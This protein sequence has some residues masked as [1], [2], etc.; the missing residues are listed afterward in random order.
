MRPA[1]RQFWW[2]WAGGLLTLLKFWLT[3]GQPVYGLGPAIHDDRLF[4]E[5]AGH[6]IRGEWLGPYNQ[7]TLAK[8]PGFPLFL[9][10]NFWLGLPLGLTQQ[11]LYAL[12]CALLVRAL[13][14]WLRSAAVS[15]SVY[16]LLLLN[17]MSFEGP[18]LTRLI[19]QNL[20][21]PL[22]LLIVAGLIALYARRHQAF[23]RQAPWAALAGFS[24]GLFW[25]TRE[26]GVWL[27]PGLIVL[28]AGLAW[29]LRRVWRTHLPDAIG[30]AAFFAGTALAP[31]L[32]VCSLNLA[33]YGWFGTVE[34]RAPEF[35]AAY[36]ALL[37]LEQKPVLTPAV[38]VSQQMREAAYA[39][40][41]AC[42]GL[43]SALEG[44]VG[45]HW[46]D[47][48]SFG[49]GT[50]EIRGGWF[51]WALR[52]AVA[53]SGHAPNAGEA[54]RYYQR[55]ADELNAAAEAGRVRAGPARSG[56]MPAVS[57]AQWPVL[58]TE[59][60]DYFLFFTRFESFSTRSPESTG[61]YAELLPL[62][63]ISRDRLSPAPRDPAPPSP[64]QDRLDARKVAGLEAIGQGMCAL[65]R[66][67]VPAAHLLWLLRLA[68]AAVAR[69]L[70]FLQLVASA[71]WLACLAQL[72]INT[73]V[74]VTSFDYKYPAAI[75][76]SYPL[77]LLFVASVLTD[78]GG[79]W[80]FRRRTATRPVPAPPRASSRAVLWLWAAGTAL[81]ILAFRLAEIHRHTG[82]VALN[83]Q[84]KIEAAD[85][86][87]PWLDG[88][89]RPWTFFIPHFEHVPAWTRLLAWLEVA[90]TGR[91]D[92][93]LQTT[94]NSLLYAGYAALLLRWL[95]RCLRPLALGA[96]TVL[97]GALGILPH[98]W[99]N[100]TWGF[101]SQFPFALLFLLWQADGSFRYEPGRAGWWRAQA[102]GVAGLFTL[103][104]MWMAPLAVVLVSLWTQPR[105]GDRRRLWPLA[106]VAAGLGIIALVR[107]VAP[108]GGAFAQ[109]AGSPLQFLHALLD[110]LGW[111]AGRPGAFILL[112]LPLLVFAL[113]LRR[114]NDATAFDRTALTLGLWSWGQ[115]AALAFA[116]SADYSGY[117]SR[118]DDLLA[119]GLIANAVAL[120][121]LAPALR[122]WRPLP[123]GFITGWAAVACVGL[124]R[125]STGGHAAYFHENSARNN[126]IRLEAVQAYLQRHDRSLLEAPE[127]RW[128]LYQ[129]VG[130][131]TTLLDR[132]DF[133]GLLPPSIN[134]ATPPDAAG[135]LARL[136]QENWMYPA[137]T[138]AVC[139]LLGAVLL[140]A[141]PFRSAPVTESA[142]F[143]LRDDP[144]LPASF[145]GFGLGAFA[146]LFCWPDPFTFDQAERWRQ[147]VQPPGSTA[148][149]SIAFAQ[150][151]PLPDSR[152]IG[153]APLSPP[154]FRNLF[155]GT[156]PEGPGYT[157]TVLSSPFLLASQW[158]VVPYAGYPVSHGNGLRI[159]LEET[160]G[161]ALT[162]VTCEG[163]NSP[164][165][166]FWVAD[167]RAYPGR[168]A[169]LVLYDGRTDQQGW[170]AAAPPIA[171]PDPAL[172]DRLAARL[173]RERI[174]PTH[175][176]LG[177][178]SLSC[179][180]L[181]LGL[182]LLRARA[183]P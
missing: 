19:R 1:P 136:A 23:R 94:V 65:L 98:A 82:D 113:Q 34:F 131:I 112:N 128:R 165:V 147:L 164:E 161:P 48:A 124:T 67:L 96:L 24:F 77:L 11:L 180:G 143:Y 139:A 78:A 146:L 21:T 3:R 33:A 5:L 64:G 150:P 126:Q 51:M 74:H 87:R 178:L 103:A 15:F 159:R 115:A 9:A 69:R 119:V 46:A 89:L 175:L 73:L 31:I 37:R 83:D 2:Y 75:A 176:A 182:A 153:A 72:A 134:P 29:S 169:R 118:Y 95:G 60:V 148:P 18:S 38:A 123:A 13:R 111:P 154:E 4:A 105:G 62:R 158:L 43:R 97:I 140:L 56:F 14:P 133:R 104:S 44:P 168:L 59:G 71:V 25:L 35:Q 45:E 102:A 39:A 179:L 85:L 66:W 183:K 41:P 50:R 7:L 106:T 28:G 101:Q 70:G 58:W 132:E 181:W 84:W 141:G 90:V 26:E 129:D 170:V 121:R 8:G 81:V 162:E 149:L 177:W 100:S 163:P 68:E 54:L 114:R 142:P 63:E 27:V 10:A 120:A 12:A 130:Q 116:R 79:V 6:L 30:S 172:A 88:T 36:G 76:P 151:G 157:G 57:P 110:L 144:W 138:G 61:D 91:W 155:F 109:T 32:T 160:E 86:L 52:D 135:R 152:L 92:P 53:V 55:I 156:A 22:A 145:A 117:V 127:T 174:A 173:P 49:P 93:L 125:L 20:T 16:A 42:A 122:D 171:T 80:I 166:A 108:P 167:V 47:H 17:P 137:G 107:A 99:E 40:S